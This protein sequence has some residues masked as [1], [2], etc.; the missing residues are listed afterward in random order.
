MGTTKNYNKLTG[1]ITKFEYETIG[2]V[3]DIPIIQSTEERNSGIPKYSHDSSSYV[4][5]DRD[6][7]RIT[8]VAF[9]DPNH[10]VDRRMDWEHGHKEFLIGSPHVQSFANNSTR[11]AN[12]YEQK[13][14]NEIK[15]R[16]FQP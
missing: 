11:Q 16:N 1:E 10:E 7:K 15:R 13:I 4:I 6:K 3:Y 5:Y 14:F 2:H 12:E 9:Y 8:Q